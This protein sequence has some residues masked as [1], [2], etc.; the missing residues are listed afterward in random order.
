MAEQSGAE[1]P[2]TAGGLESPAHL[3]WLDAERERLF[4]FAAAS[5]WPGGFGWQS[6]NGAVDPEHP[7]ELWI[8]CRMTHV[9][10]LGALQGWPGADALVDHGLAALN[11]G[12]RDREYDGW[13]A[14]I[15]AAGPVDAGKAAYQHAFV[16]LAASSA[17]AAGRPGAPELL[18]A[19]L[20]VHERWFWREADGMV[21]DAWDRT[22][23]TLDAYRGVNAN[24]HTVEAYLAAS[25]ATGDPIWRDRAARIAGRVLGWAKGNQWRIPEHFDAGWQALLEYHHDRPADQFQPYGAT[26][27]HGLEWSRLCLHL[28]AAIEAAAS[29]DGAP[30]GGAGPAEL[31]E[32]AVALF[33]RSV[34]DGWAVDGAEGFVYTTDWSGKPVVR[35]RLHWVVNEATNAAAALWSVTGDPRYDKLYQEWWAYAERY[36][37]DRVDGSWRHELDERNLPAASV[38]PGK[39]DA[40]HAVQAT[41]VPQLPLAPSFAFALRAAR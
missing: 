4:T 3:A 23:S 19:A 25:D 41:L 17:V 34:A 7:M 27:G 24:M 16:V 28:A 2:G 13:F 37:I 6:S 30:A 20:A 29:D 9:F 32:G 5:E 40:Y 36:L 38:W 22:W 26:I 35:T 12:F 11:G 8:T 15:S 14:S 33:D 31:R 1:R 10:A 39:P 21:V 18:A